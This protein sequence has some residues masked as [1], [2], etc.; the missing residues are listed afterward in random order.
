MPRSA[1]LP[2]RPPPYAAETL[3]P[4]ACLVFLLPLVAGYELG[5]VT[6]GSASLRPEGSPL[7]APQLLH[8]F[9]SIFGASGY[10]LPGFALVGIL[11]AWHL[12]SREPWRVDRWV[13]AGMAGESLLWAWPL[14]GI[15]YLIRLTSFTTHA[16]FAGALTD[17]LLGVGAGI[18][19][20]L[21]FRLM[22]ITAVNVI[23]VDLARVRPAWGT[24]AA[25]VVSS[26]L[27]AA[28]HYPPVGTDVFN[29]YDFAFRLLAGGYLAILFVLRGFGIAV[30]AHAMY[31]VIVMV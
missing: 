3:R 14:V 1:A 4:W 31:N 8:K 20:E 2:S 16:P 26:V 28:H 10:F 29:G 18:Y 17:L 21:M 7:A 11:L 5:L 25:I 9:F 23:M 13:L 30:G 15:N 19:E 22:V 27:F 12:A 6:A 24:A